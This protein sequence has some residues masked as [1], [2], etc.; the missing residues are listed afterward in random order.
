MGDRMIGLSLLGYLA[1]CQLTSGSAEAF[2]HESLAI[3]QANFMPPYQMHEKLVVGNVKALNALL[4]SVRSASQTDRLQVLIPV[5]METF[6]AIVKAKVMELD[7]DE[8]LDDDDTVKLFLEE[9]IDIADQNTAFFSLATYNSYIPALLT[10]L[11]DLHIVLSVNM[12]SL[13]IE[14]LVTLAVGNPKA[15]KKYRGPANE[16]SYFLSSFLP[17]L[18][19]LMTH[20]ELD[21]NW[22]KEISIEEMSNSDI[23]SVAEG[24]LVR[25]MGAFAPSTLHNIIMSAVAEHLNTQEDAECHIIASLQVLAGYMEI[26]HSLTANLQKH[27]EEVMQ[28]LSLHIASPIPRIRYAAYYALGQFLVYHMEHLSADVLVAILQT[29]LSQVPSCTSARVL[30]S[31]LLALVNLFQVADGSMWR[32]EHIEQALQVMQ[33]LPA[34]ANIA[35]EIILTLVITL[36][37]VTRSYPIHAIWKEAYSTLMPLL[38]AV[39]HSY[40]TQAY[41]AGMHSTQVN[42][43]SN[44]LEAMSMLGEAAGME[45]FVNDAREIMMMIQKEKENDLGGVKAVVRI[46]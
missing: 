5:L 10:A 38:R 37:E 13:F 35:Q 27:Q 6:F 39:L 25:V 43:Y 30:R 40:T 29:C 14:F 4:Q 7:A 45:L 44:L 1:E 20:F 26:S 17:Y 24:A 22:D 9:L 8:E 15:M 12:K 42:I 18:I 32:R 34:S 28:L 36:L 21:E 41:A 2:L 11:N 23:H 19:E 33:L 46:A 16:K 3:L 31:L